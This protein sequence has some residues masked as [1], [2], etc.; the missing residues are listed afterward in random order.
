MDKLNDSQTQASSALL[1]LSAS[2][3]RLRQALLPP[4][5]D[6][7]GVFDHEA[8]L[9]RRLRAVWR[10]LRRKLHGAPLAGMTMSALESWWQ[11]QPWREPTV[12]VADE[13]RHAALPLVRRH[14]ITSVLVAAGIG[15]ALAAFPPWRWHFLRRRV[16][17]LPGWAGRSLLAQLMQPS[18]QAMIAG[19]VMAGLGRASARA[20]QDEAA[21]PAPRAAPA[22]EG[23]TAAAS[24]AAP[25]ATSA[26]PQPTPAPPPREATQPD[27]LDPALSASSDTRTR[28]API[29]AADHA[30]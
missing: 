25:Q 16:K 3:A 14:P 17:A 20:G 19:L 10:A 26:P 30:T 28:P 27:A 18:V 9:P 23:G 1:R 22:D 7:P 6:S 24:A 21:A 15:A 12:L 8:W 5:D 29:R 2:R 11:R 13:L 4:E